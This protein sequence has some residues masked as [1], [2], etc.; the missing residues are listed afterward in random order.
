[1]MVI[2]VM[3]RALKL[4]Y[5]ILILLKRLYGKKLT[6]RFEFDHDYYYNRS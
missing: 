4:A 6:V 1:M 3:P 5:A 2:F